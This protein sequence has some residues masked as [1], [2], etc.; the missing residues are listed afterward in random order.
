MPM[1]N[2]IV[3]RALCFPSQDKD[4]RGVRQESVQTRA[5]P[6]GQPGGRVSDQRPGQILAKTLE[7]SS[8]RSSHTEQ[9]PSMTRKAV[10]VS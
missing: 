9:G 1:E 4:R 8:C 2:Q 10:N 3:K 5:D 7:A 6:S